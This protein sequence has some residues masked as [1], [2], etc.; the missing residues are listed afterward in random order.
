MK[1]V[2]HTMFAHLLIFASYDSFSLIYI[3][4][5]SYE[6]YEFTTFA[7]SVSNIPLETL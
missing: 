2:F 3:P 4:T 7:C 5:T 6:A 1:K